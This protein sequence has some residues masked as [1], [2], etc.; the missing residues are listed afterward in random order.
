MNDIRIVPSRITRE[1]KSNVK[2]ATAVHED[3]LAI[4]MDAM[5][6]FRE[7]RFCMIVKP[8]IVYSSTSI[9]SKCLTINSHKRIL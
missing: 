7:A 9:T 1:G 3:N 5:V 4:S 6:V 8:A 2:T